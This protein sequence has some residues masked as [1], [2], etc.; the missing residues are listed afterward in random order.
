MLTCELAAL[1]AV[2]QAETGGRGGFSE[3]SGGNSFTFPT[4]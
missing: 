2:Q 3:I 1:K 4:F